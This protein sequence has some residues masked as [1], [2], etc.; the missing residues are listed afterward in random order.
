VLEF[1]KKGEI[2]SAHTLSAPAV[3]I[4]SNNE[5]GTVVITDSGVSFGLVVIN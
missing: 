5:I 2:L 3:A 4:T 1:G